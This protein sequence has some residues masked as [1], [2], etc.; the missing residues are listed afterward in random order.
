MRMVQNIMKTWHCVPVSFSFYPTPFQGNMVGMRSISLYAVALSLMLMPGVALA[1]TAPAGGTVGD[2]FQVAKTAVKPEVQNMVVSVYGTGSVSA[3]DKWYIIFYDPKVATHG[4]AVLVQGG[5]VVKTYAA[6]G[7]ETY[8][9]LLTFD[10]SL[11]TS[12]GPALAAAQSYAAKKRISYDSVH[13]LL[14]ETGLNKP[15]RWRVEL[16]HD[17][18]SRGFVYV[19]ALDDSV[20]AYEKP[21]AQKKAA[22]T[23]NNSDG[24]GDDVKNTFLGI[25]GDLQEFFTGERTVDK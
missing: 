6:N 20:A 22:T 17:G 19:S 3:I 11:I 24:F 16:L 15:F 1:Q 18:H 2:A 23:A 7:G 12:E 4:R 21:E 9:K 14:K 8:S 10:P 13:A 5:K 25:G